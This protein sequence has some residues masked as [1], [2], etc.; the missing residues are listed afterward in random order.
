M[1]VTI[2]LYIYVYKSFKTGAF[3]VNLSLLFDF[4]LFFVL[5]AFF[6][7]VFFFFLFIEFAPS[8]NENLLK[9]DQK[10]MSRNIT[11]FSDKKHDG[12]PNF[13]RHTFSMYIEGEKNDSRPIS[14]VIYITR[15]KYVKHPYTLRV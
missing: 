11:R 15:V 9:S 14:R 13:L 3:F 12:F 4:S 8:G 7:R 2:Y 10:R 6:W 1:F 5:R